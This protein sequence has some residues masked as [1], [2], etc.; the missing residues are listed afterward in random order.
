MIRDGDGRLLMVVSDV[1]GGGARVDFG[2][3]IEWLLLDREMAVFLADQLRSRATHVMPLV[4]VK[5]EDGQNARG[6]DG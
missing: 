2:R 6:S 3:P 5:S 1:A 4:A